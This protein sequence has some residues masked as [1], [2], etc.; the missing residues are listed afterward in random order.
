MNYSSANRVAFGQR[1]LA[2]TAAKVRQASRPSAYQLPSETVKTRILKHDGRHRKRLP[3]GGFIAKT[4]VDNMLSLLRTNRLVSLVRTA[5]AAMSAP[6]RPTLAASKRRSSQ[7]PAWVPSIVT[8]SA[9]GIAHVSVLSV[10]LSCRTQLA[11]LRAPPCCQWLAARRLP[12]T[13]QI[14]TSSPTVKRNALPAKPCRESKS[15]GISR[16]RLVIITPPVDARIE[17]PVHIDVDVLP[18]HCGRLRQDA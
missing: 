17:Q 6:A 11:R 2:P 13:L 10:M 7:L 5:R 12:P 8:A 16:P 1:S 14:S 15:V 3:T 4:G 18:D 9:A